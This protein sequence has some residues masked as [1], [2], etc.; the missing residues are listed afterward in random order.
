M[1]LRS[2]RALWIFRPW[3]VWLPL[4]RRARAARGLMLPVALAA[5]ACGGSETPAQSPEGAAPAGPTSE[6]LGAPYD[7]RYSA[8]IEA[9][10]GR[11]RVVLREESMCD[12]IPV[13]SVIEDG[14]KRFIAGTP[15]KSQ[16]CNERVA[17]NVTVSLEVEGNTFRLGEPDAHGEL[18]TNLSDRMLNDLYGG[19]RKNQVAKVMLRDRQGKS[20]E[21]GTIALTQLEASERRLDELLAEF[22]A[23]LDRPQEQLTGAELA[24]AYE[25]YEQLARFDTSDPRVSGLMA[26]FME[27]LY[28]RK[29]L[30]ANERF[31][32][33]LEALNVA[34]D[35]LIANRETIVVPGYVSS[36]IQGGVMDPRTADWAR[37]QVAVAIRRNPTLCGPSPKSDFTWSR[38]QLSPPPPES[39]LAFEVLRFAYDDPYEKEITELCRRVLG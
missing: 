28:M 16:P 22:R 18:V 21:L 37:G 11:V 3:R 15:T 6:Q 39:R 26:L 27:R 2:T 4:L 32:N 19:S 23:V 8:D 14:K 7:T 9:Q 10:H 30:E 34:K 31:R 38:L 36:A 33:N 35:I 13:T 1:T 17:R 12:V 29:A 20:Q 24:R 5:G 25:L